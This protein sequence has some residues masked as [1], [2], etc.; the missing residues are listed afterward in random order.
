MRF[1]YWITKA[2]DT[3]SECVLLTGFPREQLTGD[4]AS[5]LRLN[6][7]CLPCFSLVRLVFRISLVS[8]AHRA[9][10]EICVSSVEELAYLST[11]VIARQN[12]V[13]ILNE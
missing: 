6:V 7:H 4:R 11:S 9:C 12:Y 13:T 2:T 5:I 10:S 8:Q 1:A 3:H